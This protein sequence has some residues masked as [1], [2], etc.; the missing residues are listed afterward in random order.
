MIEPSV[1]DIAQLKQEMRTMHKHIGRLG[2]LQVLYEMLFAANILMEV[3]AEE[4]YED[5]KE[6]K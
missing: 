1:L 5:E 6:S 3:I 2:A 4:Q